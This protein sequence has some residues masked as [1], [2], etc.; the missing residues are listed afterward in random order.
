MFVEQANRLQ[1]GLTAGAGAFFDLSSGARL[2]VDFRY[3]FGHSNLGF[4]TFADSFDFPEDDYVE[5]FEYT[6]NYNLSF[7]G[8]FVWL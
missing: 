3:T 1:F 2:M 5:S 4:D 6:M 8:L 7:G